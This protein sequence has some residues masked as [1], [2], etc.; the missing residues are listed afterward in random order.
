MVVCIDAFALLNGCN[1]HCTRQ[2]HGPEHNH[3]N[4]IP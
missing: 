3:A 4:E 2:Q 1:S